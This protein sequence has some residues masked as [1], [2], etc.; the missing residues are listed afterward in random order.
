[1][2]VGMLLRPRLSGDLTLALVWGGPDGQQIVARREPATVSIL[3]DGVPMFVRPPA[4]QPG[5]W[6]L[7]VQ[8]EREGLAARG[9]GI[10]VEC[11][12]DLRARAER[13]LRKAEGVSLGDARLQRSLRLLL[14]LGVRT[15]V[16]LSPGRTLALLEGGG[17][18]TWP[19]PVEQTFAEPGGREGWLWSLR[20]PGPLE[21]TLV[22]VA[23]EEELPDLVFAGTL[24]E[25][26][27][28]LA[29]EH[30]ALL[31]SIDLPTSS[32]DTTPAQLFAR[33]R[34]VALELG[35]PE[36]GE[37][38]VIGRG[39]AGVRLSYAVPRET[40]D[41]AVLSTVLPMENASQVLEGVPR[42]LVAPGGSA[43]FPDGAEPLDELVWV[44]GSPTSLFNDP[45]LPELVGTWLEARGE[46]R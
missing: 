43:S 10:R 6:T 29:T 7:A 4:S 12:K 8:V 15:G 32:A 40:Y 34:G 3:I 33:L 5:T 9:V 44:D 1:V 27:L 25:R 42:L 31:L 21:R 46:S 45:R 38:I 37:L 11:L 14:E 26:W 19:R 36:A 16:A 17:A 35:A 23:P 2:H 39:A 18:P 22:L 20:P 41:A 13:A 24:G 28:G 30:R